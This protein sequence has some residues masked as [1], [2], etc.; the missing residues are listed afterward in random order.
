MKERV[1]LSKF[2]SVI[3]GKRVYERIREKFPGFKIYICQHPGTGDVYLQS[4]FI[5]EYAS[6]QN[7]DKYVLSVIGNSAKEITSLFGIKHVV[8]LSIKESNDFV[9]FYNFI[10]G[11]EGV[12]VLHYHPMMTHQS[13]LGYARNFHDI[14]FLRMM[15][16]YVFADLKYEMMP[17]PQYSYD[18]VFVDEVF[19]KY[20]LI[21]GRTILLAPYANSLN[22]LPYDF[23]EKLCKK[24][25]NLGYS[26]VTNS[27]G[28]NELPIKGT[29]PVFIPYKYLKQFVIRGGYSISFRS[30]LSDILSDIPHNMTVVYLKRDIWPVMGGLGT[31]YEYFSLNRMGTCINAQEFEMKSLRPK[32]K[33]KCINDIL[34]VFA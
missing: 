26:V 33:E 13:V 14:N 20:R 6:S 4:K 9:V 25:I 15:Q 30:G 27:T 5:G 21:E 29:A 31:E 17:A 1:W 19:R 22:V 3:R 11:I 32:D 7:I 2:K 12:E 8:K 24:L 16:R 28:K 18:S 23:W 34:S 10:G